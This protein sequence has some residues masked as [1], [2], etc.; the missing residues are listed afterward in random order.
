V[1]EPEIEADEPH[2]D[3]PE[4]IANEA[5][6]NAD[7]DEATIEGAVNGMDSTNLD[8]NKNFPGTSNS[9]SVQ[10]EAPNFS[11]NDVSLTTHFT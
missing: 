8:E 2:P 7:L 10:D 4:P 6:L 3:D 1:N 11:M 5:D 9:F